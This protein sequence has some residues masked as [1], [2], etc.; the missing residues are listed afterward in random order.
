MLGPEIL[1]VV[2]GAPDGELAVDDDLAFQ[3]T[4][5]AFLEALLYGGHALGIEEIEVVGVEDVAQEHHDAGHGVV[6][7]GDEAVILLVGR[8]GL[9]PAAGRVLGLEDDVQAFVHRVEAALVLGEAVGAG[10]EADFGGGGAVVEGAAEFFNI[11]GEGFG[12]VVLIFD[13]GAFGVLP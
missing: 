1:F 3:N 7:E 5:D 13:P 8:I 9:G 12:G 6:V 4:L 2:L 11:A 10:E